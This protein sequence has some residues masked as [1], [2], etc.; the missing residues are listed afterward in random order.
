MFILHSKVSQRNYNSAISHCPKYLQSFSALHTLIHVLVSYQF[1]LFINEN[2]FI[3]GATAPS[4]S[5]P[6]HSRGFYI[7]LNDATQSLGHIWTSDQPVA[8]TST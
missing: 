3:F 1:L 6:P 8:E 2:F 4:G 5:W 7:T